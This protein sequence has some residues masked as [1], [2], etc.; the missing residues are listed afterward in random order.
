MMTLLHAK[1]KKK[2]PLEHIPNKTARTCTYRLEDILVKL[3]QKELTLSVPIRLK[4][5]NKPKVLFSHFF[6]VPQ[7]VFMKALKAF[8]KHFEAP[9]RS[10]KIKI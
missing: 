3:N 8:K 5:G 7:K 1:L 10:V 2:K 4:R 6:V 9:Q